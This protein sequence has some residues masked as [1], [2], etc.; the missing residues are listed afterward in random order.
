MDPTGLF[1]SGTLSAFQRTGPITTAADFH[2][3]LDWLGSF[4][5]PTIKEMEACLMN[6]TQG[7]S[8]PR[9]RIMAELASEKRNSPAEKFITS[10]ENDE[11]DCSSEDEE[12]SK[13]PKPRA[14]VGKRDGKRSSTSPTPHQPSEQPKPLHPKLM[15][16]DAVL[17][18]KNLWDEFNE[19]GT[20]MIVTKAGR[21]MFPTFQVKLFGMDPSADYMLMMDF[22][23]VDD[24]RWRYAFGS[25]SWVVAGKADANM[26]PRI[27]VHP[28]SPAKGVH[29]TKQVVSFDKLKLT[30]NQL[31]DNGHIILNSMHRYQPR[32]HAVY[33]GSKDE[34]MS[35]TENFKT[36]VFNECRFWA[37]TAYQNHRITQLKIASNPFAKGFRDCDTDDCSVTEVLTNSQQSQRRV[38]ESAS[39][40][41]TRPSPYPLMSQSAS[42]GTM[43]SAASFYSQFKA[44]KDTLNGSADLVARIFNPPLSSDAIQSVQFSSG[45]PLSP[46]TTPTSPTFTYGMDAY[47]SPYTGS[48]VCSYMSS[49]SLSSLHNPRPAPYPRPSSVYPYGYY[50]QNTAR[51][52]ASYKYPC[53]GHQ[54]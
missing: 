3:Y 49:A 2:P 4:P 17:E 41:M 38:V 5:V 35:L 40:C 30:N 39:A 34:N 54:Y 24:K 15:T 46:Q 19:L 20:E 7:A 13:L 9:D 53:S 8:S 22:V 33:V 37:V 31:D 42:P 10:E 29:W 47:T 18:T 1:N 52:L 11:D 12:G 48:D 44:T 6:A 25:S 26:P 43:S 16:V 28:D 36:F 27:H 45:S 50:G 23:P 32:F 14:H 51:Q 21:R